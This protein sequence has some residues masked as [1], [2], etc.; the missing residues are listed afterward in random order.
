MPSDNP[1]GNE[2]QAGNNSPGQNEDGFYELTASDAIDSDPE[3]ILVDKGSGS[4]FGPFASG[5]KIKYTQSP[6]GKPS[7]KK[8]GGPNSEVQWHITGKGDAEI[9]AVD[10]AGNESDPVGCFVPPPPK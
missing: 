7:Q 9:F 10:D 1:A 4:V 5:T 3:I 6:G 8:I 2:P